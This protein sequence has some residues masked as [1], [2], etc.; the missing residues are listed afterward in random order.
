MAEL[1]V[2]LGLIEVQEPG[3]IVFRAP[4]LD[5]TDRLRED[6]LAPLDVA[7]EDERPRLHRVEVCR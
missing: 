2:K 5:M 7:A 3:W 1:R 6:K 4:V